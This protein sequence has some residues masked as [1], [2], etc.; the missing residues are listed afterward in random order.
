MV[1]KDGKHKLV[2]FV[3]LGEMHHAFE[4]LSG[5]YMFMKKNVNFSFPVISN[6]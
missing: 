5:K 1:V 3:D 2:G 6:Y 4:K